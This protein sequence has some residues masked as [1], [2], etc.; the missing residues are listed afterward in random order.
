[1]SN[2]QYS[3]LLVTNNF[4]N[5]NLFNHENVNETFF[6]TRECTWANEHYNKLVCLKNA[7]KQSILK[8]FFKLDSS[9]SEF[10]KVWFFSYSLY[11]ILPRS[12]TTP[13]RLPF[14]TIKITNRTEQVFWVS[15]S[16]N[17]SCI[18]KKSFFQKKYKIFKII[19]A[20]FDT[21]ENALAYL[22]GAIFFDLWKTQCA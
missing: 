20:V 14:I 7:L 12:R 11:R 4:G 18:Q 8:L 2:N 3:K 21:Q 6:F 10:L 19:D 9:V 16:V 5:E 17:L 15:L 13:L 1:M 22:C